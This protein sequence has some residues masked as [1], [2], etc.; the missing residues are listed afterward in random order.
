MNLA[1]QGELQREMRGR[2][3]FDDHDPVPLDT[4]QVPCSLFRV[5]ICVAL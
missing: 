5:Y 1:T 3:E 4:A 2:L